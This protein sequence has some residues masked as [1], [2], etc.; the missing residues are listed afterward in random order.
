MKKCGIKQ[1]P[2]NGFDAIGF[3]V[4]PFD[5]CSDNTIA[6][7][8]DLLR[9]EIFIGRHHVKYNQLWFKLLFTAILQNTADDFASQ[10][11]IYTFRS[12]TTHC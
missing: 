6:R 8:M 2:G 10:D 1:S 5:A 9:T 3:D 4:N 12:N 11:N 7:V